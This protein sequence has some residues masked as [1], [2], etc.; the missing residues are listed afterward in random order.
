MELLK[1]AKERMQL[2]LEESVALQ[3]WINWAEKNGSAPTKN[4]GPYNRGTPR[5]GTFYARVHDALVKTVKAS[6]G[7]VTPMTVREAVGS[8]EWP[9]DKNAVNVALWRFANYKQYGVS[10]AGQGRYTV[11]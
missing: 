6:G 11:K 7:P 4:R 10:K 2:L 1:L 5:Q 3:N 8:W 9:K